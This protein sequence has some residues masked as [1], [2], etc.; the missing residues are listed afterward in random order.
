M[1]AH[2]HYLSGSELH[3][4]KHANSIVKSWIWQIHG[5]SHLSYWT[6]GLQDFDTLSDT[7]EEGL[8][9]VIGPLYLADCVLGCICRT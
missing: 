1:V 8:A 7:L 4:I 2:A 5:K 6:A 9:F 3:V